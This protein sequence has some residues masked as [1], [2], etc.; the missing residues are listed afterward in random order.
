[1]SFL[2]ENLLANRALANALG[3][4]ILH[5]LWQGTL[6]ALLLAAALGAMRRQ[7]ASYR[8]LAS[9]ATLGVMLVAFV[10]TAVYYYQ[11][12]LEAGA[13]PVVTAVWLPLENLLDGPAATPLTWA[14]CQ[15][16]ADYLQWAS[17]QV[18]ANTNWLVTCWLVG[19]AL[20]A[21][22]LMVGLAY[23]H[24]LRRHGLR[25]VSSEW[26]E[27]AQTL[28]H[29]L[30]MSRPVQFFE[31]MLVSVPTVVGWLRPVVLF[32]VGMLAALP[33]HELETLLAHEL[34]HIRRNDYL[35]NLLQ[36]LVE[37]VLFYHPALWWVSARV[38]Q[39]RE[40][41]CDD[42]AV[43]VSG[44]DAVTYMKALADLA[45]LH[46]RTPAP[47]LALTGPDGQL[48]GRIKRLAKRAEPVRWAS[49][50]HLPTRALAAAAVATALV[51]YTSHSRATQLARQLAKQA[52]AVVTRTTEQVVE[53][54]APEPTP[55]VAAPALPPLEPLAQDDT[56]KRKRIM[57]YTFENVNGQVKTDTFYYNVG[58]Q[59]LLGWGFDG[60]WPPPVA[61]HIKGMQFS[62]DSLGSTYWRFPDSLVKAKELS[63]YFQSRYLV[64]D[65]L[66]G[67]WDTVIH[68]IY[69]N[70]DGR[71]L[72]NDLRRRMG[73]GDSLRKNLLRYPAH[74]FR[75]DSLF[76]GAWPDAN[77]P[78]RLRSVEQLQKTIDK[79]KSQAQGN[80][81]MDELIQQLQKQLDQLRRLGANFPRGGALP[82]NGTFFSSGGP[83]GYT[84]SFANSGQ[85]TGGATNMLTISSP[86]AG[87]PA[88]VKVTG[89]ASL[90]TNGH[91]VRVQSFGSSD[92][93]RYRRSPR[94]VS[95]SSSDGQT[96]SVVLNGEGQGGVQVTTTGG[97]ADKPRVF[98]IDGQVVEQT[99]VEGLDPKEVKTISLQVSGQKKYGERGKNGV[100][101]I[102]TMKGGISL[103]EQPK[104]YFL[105]GQE[106]EKAVI[107]R[108]SAEQ[109]VS[110][111]VMV[112]SRATQKY[113][114]RGK[115]GVVEITTKANPRAEVI[116]RN[117][118]AKM[119]VD[120]YGQGDRLLII[121]GEE[122]RGNLQKR[123]NE[124]DPQSIKSITVLDGK[125]AVPLYG[126]KAKHG[127]VLLFTKTGTQPG[128]VSSKDS[129]YSTSFGEANFWNVAP[130]PGRGTF[131]IRLNLV[132]PAQVAVQV[133]DLQGRL[134]GE[135][136]P[137]VSLEKGVHQFKWATEGLPAGVYFL[138]MNLNGQVSTQR[139]IVE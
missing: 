100:V 46:L 132:Q 111:S 61:E 98:V 63:R 38:N 22:R 67:G 128:E 88:T 21:V 57:I 79:L 120:G 4:A 129:S 107:D 135:P 30:K 139:V 17:L 114:E 81:G 110:V 123:L 87:Q 62:F 34:A 116:R 112:G 20:F 103:A 60:A 2:L 72:A 13:A 15:T 122:Q 48:L 8:Y 1:M 26:Q 29:R 137:P 89:N 51:L 35:I 41:C 27:K 109:I 96:F 82:S 125:N 50:Q 54:I 118:Q 75:F 6:A 43:A 9:L 99:E 40:H 73:L 130:N 19:V 124:L 65:S 86:A 77:A 92:T 85:N 113:G 95:M 49:W 71:K 56:T 3:W 16:T 78:Q 47:A 68:Q 115:N 117:S 105:D 11:P 31:S 14:T 97:V 126:K 25:P 37:V 5:S 10:G 74:S 55:V 131:G 133:T 84:Y 121:D 24:R 108:L 106:V 93:S 42:L 76:Y 12:A 102:T 101:E 36:S 53:L 39:E 52:V 7:A 83:A 134:V 90:R 59:P 70:E 91:P 32:P 94:G 138:K 44:G 104:I 80:A 66:K 69:G 23:A 33:P 45:E 119:L 136:Q 64:M 28:A 18:E 58:G 127:A